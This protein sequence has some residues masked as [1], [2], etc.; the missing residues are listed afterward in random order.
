MKSFQRGFTL[1]EL[2]VVLFILSLL[3]FMAVQS[4]DIIEDQTRYEATPRA[5]ADIENAIIGTEHARDESGRPLVTGY[6]ADMGGLPKVRLFDHDNDSLTP[7]ILQPIDLWINPFA[8]G[9]ALRKADALEG[10]VTTPALE[11]AEVKVPC[12]WRGPYLRLPAGSN[13][14][15]D[16]WSNAFQLL[17]SDRSACGNGDD[18]E[19]VRS[20]GSDGTLTGAATGDYRQDLYLNLKTNAFTTPPDYP[21]ASASDRTTASFTVTVKKSDG[22]GPTAGT[23]ELRL[24][25]PNPANGLVKVEKPAADQAASGNPLVFVVPSSTIGTRVLRAY[26][27]GTSS[28]GSAPLYVTIHPQTS[29]I[30]LIWT[31][32]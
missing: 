16:G 2:V 5:L 6:I 10:G 7:P 18:L 19:I 28:P 31:G 29:S 26:S 30:T 11:D 24:F 9:F 22:T 14:L 3:T 27:G 20:L 25:G 8:T 15:R 32:P 4:V 17:K 21:A 12:G 1:V 13:V 23:I